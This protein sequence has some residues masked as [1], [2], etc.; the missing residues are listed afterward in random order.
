MNPQTR[1]AIH[2]FL[3]ILGTVLVMHG[4]TNAAALVNTEDAMGLAMTLYGVFDSWWTNRK[5]A[6]I[7]KAA[8]AIP[9][10]T[11]IPATTDAAP[12]AQ[13]MPPES[14]TEFIRKPNTQ[15]TT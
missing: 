13:V 4:A 9:A 15:T 6:I 14:A 2:S 5:S 8:D 7:Q 10:G 3:K 1:S 11:V 12:K